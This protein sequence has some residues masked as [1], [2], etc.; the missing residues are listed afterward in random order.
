MALPALVVALALGLACQAV[1][2]QTPSPPPPP[3]AERPPVSPPRLPPG[4]PP[5]PGGE[6]D[7][8]KPAV[9]E[10][11]EGRLR[12]GALTVDQRA[13]TFSVAGEVL[14]LGSPDAPLEFF[15]IAKHG[16]KAYESAVMVETDAIAF[17]LACLLIGLDGAGA[18]QPERHFDPNPV[19]GDPVTVTVSWQEGDKRI[20]R[21]ASALLRVSAGEAP[22]TDEWV[23]TGSFFLPD[24]RY[25]AH[26]VGTLIGFVHD[27]ESI[28]QHQSGLG[29]GAY[30]AVTYGG[31]A[32]PPVG[33]KVIVTVAKAGR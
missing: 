21:P 10:L 30:G 3:S 24:G 16:H 7:V 12:I 20:T 27:R 15:A 14:D 11:G 1:S 9:E 32:A 22:A 2:A 23:Y 17:N 25:A 6:A 13:R 5:L 33:T 29:L 4:P 19:N 26:L 28:I 8:P 18:T 31:P